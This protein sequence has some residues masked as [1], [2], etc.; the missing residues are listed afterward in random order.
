MTE[1][2]KRSTQLTFV[3]LIIVFI[4]ISNALFVFLVI[5][6]IKNDA[7][8]LNYA[9]IVRGSIQRI[10]KLELSG[11]KADKYISDVNTILED[12]NRHGN[13]MDILI[14]SKK[15]MELER[16]LGKEWKLLQ[17]KIQELRENNYPGNRA[18]VFEIS[19]KCWTIANALVFEAQSIS[20]GKLFF[21]RF[22][23]IIS[24]VNIAVVILI[25]VLIRRHVRNKLE[26]LAS[27]DHL[28][29]VL[30]RYSFNVIL[31]QEMKVLTR[32]QSSLSLLLLDI[33]HF[34]R[35]NDKFGHDSGDYVLRKLAELISGSMRS[36]DAFFRI[37]GEEFAVVAVETKIEQAKV[38]AEKMRNLINSYRFDKVGKVS[39]SIGIAAYRENETMEILT[40][41][42]DNALYMAKKHGRNCVIAVQ[43]G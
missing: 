2:R 37:G 39:I 42:A 41:R 4:A 19:E 38:L 22:V 21:L 15:Y 26:Y 34:K 6:R 32:R 14:R 31:R 27:Y 24:G 30:N 29:G 8:V 10:S 5:E 18:Q 16:E 7:R 9:G 3:A 13:G 12:F 23:F 28:T 17:E 25:I 43:A 20:E 36:G 40:K 1:A 11:V 33:D 35:I